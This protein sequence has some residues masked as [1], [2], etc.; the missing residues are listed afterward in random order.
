MWRCAVSAASAALPRAFGPPPVLLRALATAPALSSVAAVASAP[1]AVARKP[2][3]GV[4]RVRTG[5]KGA[6]VSRS[7]D[8]VPRSPR[9]SGGAPIPALLPSALPISHGDAKQELVEFGQVQGPVEDGAVER[10]LG[11]M[12]RRKDDV[13]RA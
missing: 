13:V 11:I 9:H 6:T 7:A 10:V 8:V 4:A 2:G 5:G 3:G 1:V 12:R